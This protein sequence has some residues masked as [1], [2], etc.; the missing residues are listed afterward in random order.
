MKQKFNLAAYLADDS[1]KVVTNDGRPVRIVCTD[2][3][4]GEK[5]STILALVLSDSGYENAVFYNADGKC[6]S[7]SA[8]KGRKD[9]YFDDGLTEFEEAI[10]YGCQVSE[11][12]AKSAAPMILDAAKRKLESEL[13]ASGAFLGQRDADI[14]EKGK[15]DGIKENEAKYK[16]EETATFTREDFDKEIEIAEERGKR[17]AKNELPKWRLMDCH[18]SDGIHNL[19]FFGGAVATC[20]VYHNMFIPIDE[21]LNLERA[22]D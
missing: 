8:G 15:A 10:I 3:K 14:Y 7:D 18:F 6:L 20:F 21:L 5:P 13:L 9:L 2:A 1:K 16:N 4:C 12:T 11:T 22:D 17:M 19:A